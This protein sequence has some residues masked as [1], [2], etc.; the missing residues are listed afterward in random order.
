MPS[1][2]DALRETSQ[3]SCDTLDFEGTPLNLL[4]LLLILSNPQSWLL[5][6]AQPQVAKKFGPF[7]DGTSNQVCNNMTSQASPLFVC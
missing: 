1:L 7:V 2:L 4:G 3:V 6:F 5:T